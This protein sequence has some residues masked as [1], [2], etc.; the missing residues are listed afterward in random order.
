MAGEAISRDIPIVVVLP[1]PRDIFRNDF[2]SRSSMREFD[3]LLTQAAE[4]IPDQ[5]ETHAPGESGYSWASMLIVEAS[6]VLI[7]IWDGAPGRG[8]GGTAVTIDEALIAD[9]PVIWI[10]SHAPYTID[11]VDPLPGRRLAPL[12]HALQSLRSITPNAHEIT[13]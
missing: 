4:I 3:Q 7:A 11:I 10:R 6:D 9:I 12:H 1:F 2:Q 5:T 8:P 13:P